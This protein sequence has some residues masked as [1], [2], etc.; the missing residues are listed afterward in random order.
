MQDVICSTYKSTISS[1]VQP[2]SGDPARLPNALSV[3]RQAAGWPEFVPLLLEARQLAFSRF[4]NDPVKAA[5]FSK[6]GVPA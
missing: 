1:K 5:L 3:L 6:H 2:P 4:H